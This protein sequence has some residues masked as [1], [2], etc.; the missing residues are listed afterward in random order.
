MLFRFASQVSAFSHWVSSIDL[1]GASSTMQ[2]LLSDIFWR[3]GGA[4]DVILPVAFG[5]AFSGCRCPLGQSEPN[6]N[7]GH[8]SDSGSCCRSGME[9]NL[10]PW[11]CLA[12]CACNGQPESPEA[13]EH[14]HCHLAC[15]LAGQGQGHTIA[16]PECG[17]D[18]VSSVFLCHCTVHTDRRLGHTLASRS[19]AAASAPR[20]HSQPTRKPIVQQCTLPPMQQLRAG[21]HLPPHPQPSDQCMVYKCIYTTVQYALPV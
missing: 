18:P 11:P 17:L 20:Q 4:H 1:S 15:A 10:G 14:R 7:H 8:A 21:A 3:F 5:F 12:V 2:L 19:A 6:L 9:W 13:S 16:S